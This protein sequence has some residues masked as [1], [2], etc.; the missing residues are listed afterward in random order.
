MDADLG[1]EDFKEAYEW[2]HGVLVSAGYDPTL[3][4]PEDFAVRV[5]RERDRLEEVERLHAA[6][7]EHCRRV[8]GCGEEV[9]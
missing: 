6:R 8:H 3:E 7:V 5:V 4:S 1:R 9:S 2:L